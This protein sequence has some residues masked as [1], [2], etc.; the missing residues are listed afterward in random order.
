MERRYTTEKGY[1]I[2]AKEDIPIG[3][4]ILEEKPIACVLNEQHKMTTCATCFQPNATLQCTACSQLVYC[5]KQCQR[6]DW[7]I[8]KLECKAFQKAQK[9]IN[10]TVRFLIRLLF[11]IHLDPTVTWIDVGGARHQRSHRQKPRTILWFRNVGLTLRKIPTGKAR[12]L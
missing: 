6:Q 9:N 7:A 2:V 1:H 10:M 3:G 11:A 5:S 8:H 12:K 4:L